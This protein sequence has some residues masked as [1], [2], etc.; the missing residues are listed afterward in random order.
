[1]RRR[2]L[3]AVSPAAAQAAPKKITTLHLPEAKWILAPS[4]GVVG[5]K[6]IFFLRVTLRREKLTDNCPLD[7]S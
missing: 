6:A 5:F 7:G 1:M 4:V 3:I 2:W